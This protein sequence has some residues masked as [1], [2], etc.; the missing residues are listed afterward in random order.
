M[1][2]RSL[3]WRMKRWKQNGRRYLV[4]HPALIKKKT[5]LCVLHY[6]NMFSIFNVVAAAILGCAIALKTPMWAV[7]KYKLWHMDVQYALEKKNYSA[8]HAFGCFFLISTVAYW[9]IPKSYSWST[10]FLFPKTVVQS[11]LVVT[12]L[13]FVLWKSILWVM[14][15]S[16]ALKNWYRR[17]VY[18]EQGNVWI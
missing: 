3:H 8:K 5:S 11:V 6:S 12:P 16:F 7:L 17:T 14:L 2:R 4:T 1:R 13:V 18:S 9:D 15:W 10:I